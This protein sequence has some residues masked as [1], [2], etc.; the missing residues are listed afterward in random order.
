MP[1]RRAD[2]SVGHRGI[3]NIA[4]LK[5]EERGGQSIKSHKRGGRTENAISAVW[6]E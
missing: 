4:W 1:D 6:Q 5:E 3:R 2:T